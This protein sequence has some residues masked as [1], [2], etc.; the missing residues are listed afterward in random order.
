MYAELPKP[1]RKLHR[2]LGSMA[3]AVCREVSMS[4]AMKTWQAYSLQFKLYVTGRGSRNQ[5]ET[6]ARS[7]LSSGL[8]LLPSLR[9]E[10]PR[11]QGP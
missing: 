9:A 6:F 1:T 4:R 3:S 10:P 5:F 11:F 7:E 2:F 8:I